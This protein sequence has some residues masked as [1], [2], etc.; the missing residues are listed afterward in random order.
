MPGAWGTDLRIDVR[1]HQDGTSIELKDAAG[2]SLALESSLRQIQLPD[3]RTALKEDLE[4]FVSLIGSGLYG[5]KTAPWANIREAMWYL[6]RRGR[7]LMYD[8]F[9]K[10]NVAEVEQFCRRA[11][12]WTPNSKRTNIIEVRSTDLDVVPFEFMPLFCLEQPPEVMDSATLYE[13]SKRLVGF[14]SILRRTVRSQPAGSS[15]VIE[16]VPNL[17][18]G[19]FHYHGLKS[20]QL[21]IAHFQAERTIQYDGPWPIMRDSD[22][23]KFKEEFCNFLWDP[24]QRFDGKRRNATTQIYHFACHCTSQRPSGKSYLTLA[25]DQQVSLDDIKDQFLGRRR[26][27][28]S[29][30]PLVF[31]NACGSSNIYPEGVVSFPTLLLDHGYRGFIGPETKIPDDFAG[32]FARRLY[33]SFLEGD[34]LGEAILKARCSFLTTHANPLGI[35]YTMYANPNFRVRKPN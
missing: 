18:I 21:A 23:H 25:F 1:I 35:L 19:L 14:T 3:Q 32:L 7:C 15:E 17:P 8:V 13:A 12:K 2:K 9:G 22:Q 29:S 27:S 6:R 11:C 4:R 33:K 28:G 5:P 24:N 10:D 26:Q 20:V 31:L 16:N 34:R 30:L